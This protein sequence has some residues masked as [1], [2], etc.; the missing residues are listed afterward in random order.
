MPRALFQ[1]TKIVATLG[2]STDHPG[3]LRRLLESGLDVARI[4]AAHGAPKDHIRRIRQVREAAKQLEVPIA[5]LV[6]MPGP[7][8]RLGILP[9]SSRNLLPR[10]EIALTAHGESDSL[11][12]ADPSI[13]HDLKTGDPIYLADGTV[14]LEVLSVGRGYARCR[15]EIGGTV[16]SGSGLNLPGSKL[17]VRLPTEGD[18][19]AIRTAVGERAEWLGVSFVRRAQDLDDVRKVLPAHGARPRLVAK[20]EKR[21]ALHNLKEIA[22]AA[23]ALMV[24]RGDLGVET[25]L[26]A[27]PLAQ[28][29]IILEALEAGKPVITATQMLE[30]MVED[31]SPTRAEVADVANALL[32]GTD[33][34]MLSAETAIGA[35]PVEAVKTLASV[36]RATESQYPYGAVL[37]RLSQVHWAKKEDALSLAIVRLSFDLK[38]SSIVLAGSAATSVPRIS[39]FRPKAPII[40]LSRNTHEITQ[41]NLTWN[42][43]PMLA[44]AGA[45][46][47]SGLNHFLKTRGLGKAGEA[48]I[49][50]TGTPRND[51]RVS[52]TVQVVRL[53]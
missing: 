43:R 24:A 31:P 36:I 1:R 6:D 8:H 20:I 33:A 34:V 45:D 35:H 39:R 16:R 42:L 26:E 37:E 21:D 13:L 48:V 18:R 9:S 5:I 47:L 49:L 29:K 15:I 51:G 25:P 41:A 4:N 11:P 2:P 32:D 23:D 40:L 22:Q 10:R 46:Q 52:D 50:V 12:L 17:S 28:K 44:P 7:K 38:A 19:E 3:V 27:V 30:S 53:R 14:R